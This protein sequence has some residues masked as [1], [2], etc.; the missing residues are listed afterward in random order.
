MQVLQSK[1]ITVLHANVID[2]TEDFMHCRRVVISERNDSHIT[3][4]EALE[5]AT[6]G[7]CGV[8][9]SKDI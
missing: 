1:D 6:Q 2:I 4:D 9:F 8:A 5:Q 7:R 3:Q